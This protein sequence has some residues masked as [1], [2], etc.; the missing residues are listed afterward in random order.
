MTPNSPYLTLL[1]NR[2]DLRQIPFTERGARLLMFCTDDH[3]AVRLTER[4]YKQTGELSAYRRRAP[5]LEEVC[6]IDEEGRLLEMA[7]TT[8]PHC[9]ECKTAAGIF[10]IAFLDAET[11]IVALPAARC[12]VS[13]RAHLDQ[14]YPDRRGGILRLTGDIRR[15]VA[16][17]TNARVLHN[18][19][20]AV[21][22][23][24]QD[25]RLTVDAGEGG[26][27]L[28]INITPRL[29]FNRWVPQPEAAIEAAAQRWHAWFAMAPAV[30]D[31]FQSQYY[32]AWWIMRAGLVS[33]RYY[34]TRETMMPS[35]IH[36]VGVWQWDNFFHAL[37]YRQMDSRLAEDQ[38]R[39]LL[40]HQ[41]ADGMI[42]DAV[43]DEGT[44]TH[45]AFPVDADVTKPPLFAWAAWK[46]YELSH[47]AEFLSEIYD[48]LVRW[49]RWWFEY[50]DLDGDGLCEY[51]HPFS[52]GLDDSPLWDDGMPVTSPD[53]NTYLCLQQEALSKI[54]HVI[55]AEEDAAMWARRADAMVERMMAELWD[56]EAGLFWARHAGK[57]VEART[58]FNLFPLLTGRLPR[59]VADRLVAHLADPRE[60]WSHYPVPTVALDDPKFDPWQMWRGPTWVN[61]NYLLIEGL[62]RSGYAELAHELRRRTLELI[63]SQNDI[64]E[65]YHPES[66]VNPPKAA[67]LFGW[68][69]AV[70]IDLA[71]QA[72]QQHR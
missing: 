63:A 29:G 20:T 34:T 18:E 2:I 32:Y 55:G 69:A 57:R 48:P 7:L 40:D 39:I 11:L 8:Y 3:F 58:P 47:D 27:A 16:Y 12:G 62:M 54:A 1:K 60:F 37:A 59:T 51:Q 24:I 33:T 70:Y 30:A 13:F 36:Y 31:E 41:R 22:F 46:I 23:D 67:S 64:Y 35:K 15:N 65:Y 42:P 53:L 61:V 26:K 52:S 17:T 38:L 45:L 49:N 44:V 28:L 66:G 71:I 21:S 68:S 19:V 4:W 9:L 10:T 14:A 25:V 5:I 6:F 43:H 72:S 56:E 50:N